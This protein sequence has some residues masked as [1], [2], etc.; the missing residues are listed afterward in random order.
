MKNT[1]HNQFLRNHQLVECLMM[2][3]VL[4]KKQ[5]RAIFM[6]VMT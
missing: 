6:G 1:I 4:L 3:C 5:I 2:K